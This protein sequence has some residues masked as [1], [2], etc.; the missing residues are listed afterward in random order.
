MT[1]KILSSSLN[2]A[3]TITSPESGIGG[4]VKG[5]TYTLGTDG[6]KGLRCVRQEKYARFPIEN[7]DL[8]KG[9]ITFSYKPNYTLS[10]N[11]KEHVILGIGEDINLLPNILLRVINN[12]IEL[13]VAT[14]V[15][16]KKIVT[17]T[18][19]KLS[20]AFRINFKKFEE[21]ASEEIRRGGPQRY[22]F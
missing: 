19:F 22:A 8:V 21:F 9:S 11:V 15:G 16:V 1:K 13:S 3:S 18:A 17:P 6:T 5:F 2:S 14:Q 12:I 10:T 4:V 7:I 20:N